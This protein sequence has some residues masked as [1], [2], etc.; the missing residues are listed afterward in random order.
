MP[1]QTS[2]IMRDQVHRLVPSIMEYDV[3]H[4]R[5]RRPDGLYLLTSCAVIF[6][7]LLAMAVSAG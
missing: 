4:G 1:R 6:V 7:Y 5:T 2:Y 3:T